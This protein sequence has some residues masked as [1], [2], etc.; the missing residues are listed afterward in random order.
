MD[1]LLARWNDLGLLVAL[2]VRKLVDR[3]LDD[4]QR[5]LDFLVSDDEWWCHTDDVLVGRFRLSSQLA[6]NFRNGVNS[7][8]TSP[9]LAL[10]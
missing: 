7:T 3:L 2:E 10:T 9:G 1:V 8:S 4:A 5:G 6:V